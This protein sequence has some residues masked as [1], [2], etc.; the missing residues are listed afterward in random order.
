MQRY[1]EICG[2]NDE[3][4]QTFRN[5][6][7]QII[8]DPAADIYNF[9]DSGKKLDCP[10]R[11]DTA[12]QNDETRI[13]SDKRKTLANIKNEFGEP[14]QRFSVIKT[15]SP[16]NFHYVRKDIYEKNRRIENVKEFKN[17]GRAIDVQKTVE[18]PENIQHLRRFDPLTIADDPARQYY[19]NVKLKSPYRLGEP[20]K[21][22]VMDPY[23]IAREWNP[24]VEHNVF[25]A[26]TDICSICD[27]TESIS[28]IGDIRIIQQIAMTD[29]NT[30]IAPGD[31]FHF[32]TKT[33][34]YHAHEYTN[35]NYSIKNETAIPATPYELLRA[36][37][38]EYET[39]NLNDPRTFGED[40]SEF[41]DLVRGM[42]M[43][44][45][46][47]DIRTIDDQN[48]ALTFY[49]NGSRVD[50]LTYIRLITNNPD[51]F[52]TEILKIYN[53]GS[54]VTIN[55]SF[56]TI[57]D[58]DLSL[59][60]QYKIQ[61][62]PVRT[63]T[64]ANTLEYVDTS[65]RKQKNTGVLT[66]F[67]SQA[68]FP[69]IKNIF[70]EIFTFPELIETFSHILRE[71][72]YDFLLSN[73][74]LV[75]NGSV[76]PLAV[77]DKHNNKINSDV[78]HI[79]YDGADIPL[80]NL[81]ALYNIKTS[82]LSKT[83]KKD[84]P[85]AENL[86]RINNTNK[87]IFYYDSQRDAWEIVCRQRHEISYPKCHE[88]GVRNMQ[89]DE[90]L[91]FL[92]DIVKNPLDSE[93]TRQNLIG[94]VRDF[95]ELN[96]QIFQD[97][98]K[99]YITGNVEDMFS[100]DTINTIFR[101][102]INGKRTVVVPYYG[103][104]TKKDRYQTFKQGSMICAGYLTEVVI[105]YDLSKLRDKPAENALPFC[106][107]FTKLYDVD[108]VHDDHIELID[109][110][111]AYATNNKLE[112]IEK[113]HGTVA[114]IDMSDTDVDSIV[115][116][117]FIQVMF[118]LQCMSFSGE[119]LHGD[120]TIHNVCYTDVTKLPDG[121]LGT[122]QDQLQTAEYIVYRRKS[123]KEPTNILKYEDLYLPFVGTN[124]FVKFLAKL[125][126][127]QTAQRFEYTYK[128]PQVAPESIKN[129]PSKSLSWYSPSYDVLTF[130]LS[131][132]KRFWMRSKFIRR[133]MAWV[134]D[135]AKFAQNKDYMERLGG[136][137]FQ[138]EPS[139][140]NHIDDSDPFVLPVGMFTIK[141]E[142]SSL[143]PSKEAKRSEWMAR[144]LGYLSEGFNVTHRTGISAG[145]QSNTPNSNLEHID[146][147]VNIN[148]IMTGAFDHVSASAVI[149]NLHLFGFEDELVYKPLG[150][151][152]ATNIVCCG[153][154][155]NVPFTV[156]TL[157]PQLIQNCSQ[158]LA[159]GRYNDYYKGIGNKL[160]ATLFKNSKLEQLLIN[161]GYIND[162]GY[163]SL[164][165]RPQAP[166]IRPVIW[167]ETDKKKASRAQKR[168][169]AIVRLNNLEEKA[170]KAQIA[171]SEEKLKRE[172]EQKKQL[173]IRDEILNFVQNQKKDELN[174]EVMIKS[175]M[176]KLLEHESL[177][178]SD[179]ENYYQAM[180]SLNDP[181]IRQHPV[182]I[183]MTS[184]IFDKFG[185]EKLRNFNFE[186]EDIPNIINEHGVVLSEIDPYT[187]RGRDHSLRQ[188]LTAYDDP[189]ASSAIS[190]RNKQILSEK[191]NDEEYLNRYPPYTIDNKQLSSALR[192]PSY[193]EL[194]H[195][196]S[197]DELR[198]G[199]IPR[200][201]SY[202]RVLEASIKI[203]KEYRERLVE[204][205]DML[206]TSLKHTY[207]PTPRLPENM[208]SALMNLPLPSEKSENEGVMLPTCSSSD[209]A[210]VDKSL[211]TLNAIL[212]EIAPSDLTPTV[213]SSA[214][215]TPSL[216]NNFPVERM[217]T[218]YHDAYDN[219]IKA[220]RTI[221]NLER[222][223]RVLHKDD[224]NETVYSTRGALL[225][226]V[227]DFLIQNIWTLRKMIPKFNMTLT[228]LVSG[229][230]APIDEI[231]NDVIEL[232]RKYNIARQSGL[233][234]H[235][236]NKL[237]TEIRSKNDEISRLE[238]ERQQIYREIY[239]TSTF[240]VVHLR[241]ESHITDYP[242]V[243]NPIHGHM[244]RDPPLR[245]GGEDPSF[246]VIVNN[247][248]IRNKIAS[249][250]ANIRTDP[251]QELWVR[252]FSDILQRLEEINV[253]INTVNSMSNKLNAKRNVLSKRQPEKQNKKDG[254]RDNKKD[255]KKDGKKDKKKDG[256]RDSKKDNKKDGKKDGKYDNKKDGKYDKKDNKKDGKRDSEK[257]GKYDKKDKKK[258][259]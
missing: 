257:D 37:V 69:Y 97:D 12:L 93:S 207:K 123:M 50:I 153:N 241:D 197:S 33:A 227:D 14:L 70:D 192:V 31:T 193:V 184:N 174:T 84:D 60:P 46:G 181:V 4:I 77:Y 15:L 229:Y 139:D 177:L 29:L 74:K 91:S 113:I 53:P 195:T 16:H 131:L 6:M 104:G 199:G 149:T 166:F 55:P 220:T 136:T 163:I 18:L 140:D 182:S 100:D 198:N 51:V 259:W 114:D 155:S 201:A 219:I 132:F 63:T 125:W 209:S 36:A 126:N 214:Y 23:L 128:D 159:S 255:D 65:D 237:Q 222:K 173:E 256:K 30:S 32:K 245:P 202:D 41:L 44:I 191:S 11:A 19:I 3:S 170:I 226:R 244:N 57:V 24:D 253:M 111:R 88:F 8:K 102:L 95:Y 178:K 99:H 109:N 28:S 250:L 225:R 167:E 233:S 1:E 146:V 62:K 92:R 115:Q 117:I 56:Y 183:S 186:A 127:F 47:T 150:V 248:I 7:N 164:N 108:F 176:T 85:Y 106:L 236:E 133:V 48:R 21:K 45:F 147:G 78:Y 2:I 231:T 22:T 83:S 206:K 234:P 188:I 235:I 179:V 211:D 239:K 59:L 119:V 89:I 161:S 73:A 230:E 52:G 38:D 138:D 216:T 215:T 58:F 242:G 82:K 116:N 42:I 64:I 96:G 158:Q 232:Q 67:A 101:P 204:Y 94:F 118:A 156:P 208:M 152:A 79:Q 10:N 26:Y 13:S 66:A 110:E 20:I 27:F 213:S 87:N 157:D 203:V 169:A 43:K 129:N 238:R 130:V 144:V 258:S 145:G 162:K 249:Y 75:R 80:F 35:K 9:F 168:E 151:Y 143:A 175:L 190:F 137:E 224:D 90:L 200:T 189:D 194:N 240:E 40:Y 252:R 68:Y 210:C 107:N 121:V 5:A 205:I 76:V 25:T 171:E 251:A 103:V 172:L 218:K 120:L 228:K 61:R 243:V 187:V 49:Y 54:I 71:T 39:M 196:E 72:K 34:L 122:L 212:R 112:Y 217:I 247:D 165:V 124:K 254:K 246:S 135:S 185:T 148:A 180:G 142:Q 17:V 221:Q 160:I 105:A 81:L 86:K 141:P 134:L 223:R 98:K 154:I